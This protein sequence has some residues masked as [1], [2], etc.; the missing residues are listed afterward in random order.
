M[1]EPF[2]QIDE[3]KL[4][5]RPDGKLVG[6]GFVQF[7]NMEDASK[8]IFKTNKS[9]F[10]G[11]YQMFKFIIPLHYFISFLYMFIIGRTISSEWAIPKS[12]F[13]EKIKKEEESEEIKEENSEEDTAEQTT[14]IQES[15]TNTQKNKKDSFSKKNTSSKAEQR[16]LYKL[17]KRQKRSRI[18]IRNLPFT[19]TE[20]AVKERFSKYGNIEEIRMM[21][22]PN[23]APTGC[24]FL[25]FDRVQAAAQSIHHENLKQFLDRSIV[26]D[27]AIAKDK[28]QKSGEETQVKSENDEDDGIVILKEEKNENFNE[29]EVKI[30][31]EKESDDEIKNEDESDKEQSDE[32]TD[33]DANSEDGDD[34]EN[35]EEGDEK[36]VKLELDNESVSSQHPRRISNDVSEGKTVFI[37]NVP[38]SAKNEDLKECMEQ[39]GPVY[40][41]LV[42][43][44]RLTEHSRGTAFV[45]FRVTTFFYI[46]CYKK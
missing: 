42:C 32:V 44:D 45:K 40:Y 25:Q 5:K 14:E 8:A 35:E 28:Y 43:M 13:V 1:Y 30:K 16:K 26:V 37:K 3:I 21:K 24:C 7:R 29:G 23:G 27:W 2:G 4:L 41:A 9:N 20:E 12:Q 18:I 19:I 17:K 46:S 33:D 11:K 10:L 6:C 36:N 22:K 31:E 38:F 39:F 34:E 15:D